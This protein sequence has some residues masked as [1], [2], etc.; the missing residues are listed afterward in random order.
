MFA[1]LLAPPSAAAQ[2]TASRLELTD[3]EF[4]G[5]VAFPDDS[6][7][8]AIVNRESGCRP[9]L[10]VFC[11]MGLGF[12]DDAE[13]LVR[14]EL[15][16]DAARLRIYYSERGYREALVDTA[17]A[18]DP[19]ASEAFVTFR[20]AEGQPV[21]IDSLA[22]AGTAVL[23]EDVLLRN[24]PVSEGIPLS[25]IRLEQARDSLLT[26]LRND[27]F[28]HA[29]VF[30]QRFIPQDRP[31]AAQVTYEIDAGPRARVGDL[32]I[33]V[34]GDAE[35]SEEVVRQML[36]FSEGSLYRLAELQQGQRNLYSL[37]IARNALIR[38]DSARLDASPDTLVP[39]RVE[40]GTS[41][42][43]RV[44]LGG[45][46]NEA[47]CLTAEARWANRNLFG[48]AERLQISGRLSNVLA[49]ELHR[50]ACPHSGAGEFGG[51]N[52]S[53]SADLNLPR[54]LSPLASLSTSVYWERQSLPDVFIRQSAGL[55][56]ALTRILGLRMPL[57]V[58]YRPQLTALEAAGVFFCTSLLVCNPEDIGV[59][60]DPNWLSPVGL[61]LTRDRTDNFLNP[62]QGYSA[63]LE[64]EHA[65]A[66]T[67]S[68]FAFTRATA[69]A[70]VYRELAR[71]TVA[72]ARLRWGWVG[73]AEF[74]EI[75]ASGV[76]I[77]HPQK[78][79]FA[80]GAN[81]VRGFAQNRLGPSVLTVGAS[82]LV[83]PVAIIEGDTVLLGPCTPAQIGDFTCDAE[84][85]ADG[86]FTPRP[87]GGTRLLEGSLEYR[88][89]VST[90]FQ[91]VGFVD[92]GQVWSERETFD[93]GGVEW[94][95]GVGARY[96]SPIGP[97]RVDLGYRFGGAEELPVVTSRLRPFA[98][99]DELEDRVCLPLSDVE[100]AASRCPNDE[101]GVAIPWVRRDA[102]ALLAPSVLFGEDR[103]FWSRLQIHLSIGQAF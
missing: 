59:L 6:L 29:D 66:L 31:Y 82:E 2:A 4:E 41:T 57:V 1:A 70:S 74:G 32:D 20:I 100:G 18:Y 65:S 86:A 28:V 49:E 54:I 21:L 26:R 64:F 5:N 58:S 11:W 93:V 61:A 78:R 95:P 36:P 8:T 81:S 33:L 25:L 14:R 15:A 16:A 3:L 30:L 84:S 51:L 77:I 72:A 79:F 90:N 22:F 101:P 47:D 24:L 40:V 48:G 67:G 19:E 10:E 80:G 75:A 50:N 96:F 46:W 83:G 99:G 9:L 63:H 98:A 39:L 71:R 7:R 87:T 37:E 102:L 52:W 68:D 88:F 89:A 92:F 35:L 34:S 62:S 45:G 53:I 12:A 85:L 103:S 73:A 60:E 76:Q 13:Y 17:V 42:L 97:L 56:V 38:I 69:D 94:T 27:G 43:H 44:R 91:G 55:N 23:G